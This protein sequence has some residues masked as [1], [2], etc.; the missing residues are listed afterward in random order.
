MYYN[1]RAISFFHNRRVKGSKLPP[2][3]EFLLHRPRKVAVINIFWGQDISARISVNLYRLFSCCL[4]LFLNKHNFLNHEV[5]S[6][7]KKAL[8]IQIN[9]KAFFF[10][11]K[12]LLTKNSLFYFQVNTYLFRPQ[13]YRYRFKTRSVHINRNGFD[14]VSELHGYQERGSQI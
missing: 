7:K 4:L 3:C 14:F 1:R 12:I 5:K 8:T 13:C 11:R 2:L 10:F 9:R 6:K